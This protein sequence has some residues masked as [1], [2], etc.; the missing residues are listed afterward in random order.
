MQENNTKRLDEIKDQV[1]H[2]TQCPLHKHRIHA[3]FGEGPYDA[4]IFIIGEAPGAKE[5][6]TGRPFVGRAGKLIDE[7]LQEYGLSRNKNVF[8]SNIVKCRPPKNRVP[9]KK[10]VNLCFSYIEKQIALINPGI[11][12]LLGATALKSFTG[13]HEK[14]TN[15]RGKWWKEDGRVIIPTYHPAAVFRNPAYRKFIKQ[16]IQT[17]SDQY[18]AW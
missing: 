12:V 4:P 3:V 5:D 1:L 8:I 13:T 15:V 9:D 18:Q 11:L 10:E 14:I 6:E 17:I 2:C 16:D 7:L